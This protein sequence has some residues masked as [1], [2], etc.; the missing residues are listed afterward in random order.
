M[1][2]RII[3]ALIALFFGQVLTRFGSF[4]L[5]PLFTK[6]WTPIVYGEW[7]TLS[8]TVAYIASLDLG[9]NQ[10][11]INKL[12]QSFATGSIQEY[13]II[14]HSA[15]KL[16]TSIALIGFILLASVLGFIPINELLGIRKTAPSE[17]SITLLILGAYI[18]A[19]LPA[20]MVFSIY[21]TTGNLAKTQWIQNI[22]SILFLVV[23]IFLLINNYGMIYV[24]AIQFTLQFFAIFYVLIDTK[25]KQAELFP[26][27]KLANKNIIKELFKPG[28]LFT[29][30]V[31]ANIIWYQG[32]ILLI[33]TVFGGLL[34]AT[35]SVTRT[36]A[37]L[38]RQIVSIFYSAVFPDIAILKSTD[39]NEKL[40]VMHR[41]LIIVSSG[42]SV[43]FFPL[44]WFRGEHIISL[45][46]LGEIKPDLLLLQLLLLLVLL[47]SPYLASA[48]LPL[49]T[50][51]HK[52]F[53]ILFFVS[54]SFGIILSII[55]INKLGIIALPLG[56]IIGEA[57]FCYYF[58]LKD[59]C[60]MIDEQ[61]KKFILKIYSSYAILILASF[62][63]Q[64]FLIKYLSQISIF[65]ISISLS[66]NCILCFSFIW[67]FW[68]NSEDKIIFKQTL[69]K[70]KA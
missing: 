47:Q 32:A 13:K 58:I 49:A 66:L 18:L 3:K 60:R 45:W 28:L 6:H 68:F 46:T 4:I 61:Y 35:F 31:I 21:Q 1:F 7:L 70:V 39:Q 11:A 44:F 41:L 27:I 43:L 59:T 54:Q 25:F 8:A 36:L 62:I 55:F 40:R 51:N 30:I 34:V 2:K 22:Q 50:N 57:I 33:S 20:K 14:Q 16:F 52:K 29:L 48:T 38:P 19:S 23:T 12:T 56:F 53:T 69:L 65:S 15:L 9:V 42:F 5:V 37:L 10:A 24:A 26:G 17:A 63:T 67:F 64:Y